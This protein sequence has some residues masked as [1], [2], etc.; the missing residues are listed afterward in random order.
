MVACAV[1]VVA[2]WISSAAGGGSVCGADATGDPSAAGD[3][4]AWLDLSHNMT[5]QEH[6]FYRARRSSAR[7]SLY[8]I[9]SFAAYV[10]ATCVGHDADGR[11]H[12]VCDGT[13]P[14]QLVRA[15][16]PTVLYFRPTL[17]NHTHVVVVP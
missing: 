7:E 11:W 6:Q 13:A 12:Q 16:R 9:A 8:T 17:A 5:G 14:R 2:C 1:P 10:C 4:R 3:P 15:A